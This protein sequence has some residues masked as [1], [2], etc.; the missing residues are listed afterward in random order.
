MGKAGVTLIESD[1][2]KAAF[3]REAARITATGVTILASR[4]ES[5]TS[6]PSDQ[7]TARAFAPIVRLLEETARFITPQTKPLSAFLKGQNVEAE[8][9]EAHKIWR[10]T[11]RS[12]S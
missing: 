5:L 9:T 4:L 2:R 3:L 6:L 8:L 7:F 12:H 11:A 1:Q 10:M